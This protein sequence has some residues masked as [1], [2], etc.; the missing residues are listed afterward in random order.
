MS[1]LYVVRVQND[2][3]DGVEERGYT[4]RDA[5]MRRARKQCVLYW[6]NTTA[7]VYRT[8]EIGYLGLTEILRDRLQPVAVYVA[9][10]KRGQTGL[11]AVKS[12]G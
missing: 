7:S 9:R 1:T 3:I 11:K 4:R 2:T 12:K 5:A 6:H 10:L 8:R